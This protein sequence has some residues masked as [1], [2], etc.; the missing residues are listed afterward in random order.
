MG[1]VTPSRLKGTPTSALLA[2][3]RQRI[4]A[5]RWM[6]AGSAM[7]LLIIAGGIGA[8]ALRHSQERLIESL[9][10]T[11]AF[12]KSMDIARD[13]QVHFKRQV[14]EWKNVLIRGHTMADY[15]KYWSLFETEESTTQALLLELGL[16]E[17]SEAG[18][19]TSLLREGSMLLPAIPFC[20]TLGAE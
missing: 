16:R 5:A 20:G 17:P 9:G 4:P 8:M 13:A 15:A 14:Q 18:A 12:A 1:L 11:I 2:S 19:T 3:I 7:L 6:L 10:K